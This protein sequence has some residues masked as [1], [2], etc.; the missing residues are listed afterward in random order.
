MGGGWGVGVAQAPTWTT[1]VSHQGNHAALRPL[2][3]A[4]RA[5]SAEGVPPHRRRGAAEVRVGA[6]LVT[7]WQCGCV[8]ALPPL[9]PCG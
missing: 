6:G 4:Q 8:A 2:Y 7:W 3:Q 9:P 1:V 5:S